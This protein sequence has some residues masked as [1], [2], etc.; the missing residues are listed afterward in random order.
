MKLK[1]LNFHNG[2]KVKLLKKLVNKNYVIGEIFTERSGK[3]A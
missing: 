1:L 2:W 3:R